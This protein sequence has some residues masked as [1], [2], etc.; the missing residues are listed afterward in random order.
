MQLPC[1]TR[2]LQH[3]HAFFEFNQVHYGV[4][5]G[6]Y[7]TQPDG[8]LRILEYR[9]MVQVGQGSHTIHTHYVT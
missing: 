5:E 1:L 8:P 6:S 9:E 3:N 4:P 7:S 2:F